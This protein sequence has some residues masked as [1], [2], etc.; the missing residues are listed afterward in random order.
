M[1]SLLIILF[2]FIPNIVVKSRIIR[3]HVQQ[4]INCSRI[5][6]A[7]ALSVGEFLQFWLSTR[8]P[9]DKFRYEAKLISFKK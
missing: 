3:Q 8:F 5:A 2:M 7:L 6:S 1:I 9:R 4:R